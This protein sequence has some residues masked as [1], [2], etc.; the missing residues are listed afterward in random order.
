MGL[1][2][3]ALSMTPNIQ[4]RISDEF[5]SIWKEKIVVYSR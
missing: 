2:H 5:K 1:L 4:F 3:D